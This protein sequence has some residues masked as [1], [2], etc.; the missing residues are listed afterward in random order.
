MK[1]LIDLPEMPNEFLPYNRNDK[2]DV[3]KVLSMQ[4]GKYKRQGMLDGFEDIDMAFMAL[5][6]DAGFNENQIIEAFRLVY[7]NDFNF[8]I[9][10][11]MYERTIARINNAEQIRGAGSFISKIKESGLDNIEIFVKQLS[12]KEKSA[13]QDQS[14][15]STCVE[16]QPLIESLLKWNDIWNL[17]VNI[18]YILEGLIPLG[19]IILLF[20]RGGIGKTSLCMQFA[21]AI[22]SGKVFW[23]LKTIKTPVYYIDFENPLAILKERAEK[24]GKTDNLFVWHISNKIPPPRL[25]SNE[26]EQYKQL[27]IGLLIID[28]LRAAHLSDENDSRQMALIMQRLK[29]LRELGFTIILL[30]HTPK[31]NENTYKG[32]TVILD[33]ADH[34]LGLEEVKKGD[35]RV[36]FSG[37]NYYKLGVRIKTRFNPFSISLKYNPDIKGFDIAQQVQQEDDF[38]KIYNLIVDL[39]NIKEELP[40]QSEI[41]AKAIKEL[42]LGDK[43]IRALLNAGE[44]KYWNSTKMPERNNSRVFELI[45]DA[46]DPLDSDIDINEAQATDEPIKNTSLSVCQ[47]IGGYKLTNSH[48]TKSQGLETSIN[49]G[50]DKE[51]E[52]VSQSLFPDEPK[53]NYF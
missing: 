27:P 8:E 40:I 52:F 38:T 30:H 2:N 9:T 29:E 43:K 6:I 26:W 28:T 1:S 48:K 25:D 41:I 13:S 16:S 49:K 45:T 53:T 5:L 7:L 32:S 33:L 36:E 24:I 35:D 21:R 19:S 31:G 14:N 39:K 47:P 11:N 42:K 51:F 34:I 37:D 4:I 23:G 18:E 20:G 10:L 17:D 44:G 50:L 3:I 46:V 15:Y 22:A 12:I